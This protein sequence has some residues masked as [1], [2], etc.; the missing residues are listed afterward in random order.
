MSKIK[1]IG[2]FFYLLFFF[3]AINGFGQN[4]RIEP[5]VSNL[6]DR[7]I[8]LE[9]SGLLNGTEYI[10]QPITL[11]EQHKYFYS[12]D[13]LK[14]NVKYEGEPYFNIKLKYNIY[15]DVL[16]ARIKNSSGE[17]TFKLHTEKV[18]GFEI[19]NHH[20]INIISEEAEKKNIQGFHEV[21]LKNPEFGLFKK[22]NRKNF[23]TSNSCIL[24]LKMMIRIIFFIPQKPTILLIQD[25]N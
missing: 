8:G 2:G 16:L 5:V 23:W 6:V 3:Q 7:I 9:N 13:F 14:G 4:N 12:S 17:P 15:E 20:F 18:D 24:N 1:F 10:E 11:N 19:N 25:A 21:L 22:Y